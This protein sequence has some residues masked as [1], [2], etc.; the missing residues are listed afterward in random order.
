MFSNQMDTPVSA[1]R[2]TVRINMEIEKKKY[3]F[4]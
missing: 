2:Q 3:A 1:R 4:A